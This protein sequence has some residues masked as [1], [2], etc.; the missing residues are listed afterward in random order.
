MDWRKTGPFAL[1]LVAPFIAWLLADLLIRYHFSE[2]SFRG[3][4]FSEARWDRF[5]RTTSSGL[6]TVTLGGVLLAATAAAGCIGKWRG[7]SWLDAFARAAAANASAFLLVPHWALCFL[8]APG[9]D[10]A[11]SE[12]FGWLVAQ[13]PLVVS[14]ALG[15]WLAGLWHAAWPPREPDSERASIAKVLLT[16]SL[17]AAA[18]ATL[19]IM[20]AAALHVP[21]GDTAMYEEHLWNALHGKGFRSQLDDGRLFLGEHFQMLHLFLTPIYLFYPSLAT[22]NA[23]QAIALASGALAVYLIARTLGLL[24]TTGW[25]LAL[26]YLAYFPLQ[27]LCLEASWKTFRPTSLAVPLVLYGLLALERHRL[28]AAAA[29]LAMTLLAEEEYAILVAAVG[30]YLAIRRGRGPFGRREIG[31]GLG[32]T[33]G[34]CLFLVLALGVLIPSFRHGQV[35]HYTPYFG[36]LGSS[37]SE[38][39]ATLLEHPEEIPKRLATIADGQF[40]LLMLLPLG[41]LPLASPARMLVTLPIFGYL[42]L[43]DRPALVQPWFHFHGPLVP[44]L[45]W[46]MVGGVANVGRWLDRWT[47]GL[48]LARLVA[49]LCL[50][51]GVWY[52]RSPLSWRFHDPTDAVPWQ[53]TPAGPRF[54]PRGTYW[55][56][57]YLPRERARAFPSVMPLIAPT[58]RVAATDYLRPR[59]THHRAAHDYP[60]LR[61][62][63]TIDDIDVILIDKTE[64]WWGRGDTNPDKELLAC[65]ADPACGP[66]KRL[67]IRERPFVVQYHDPYFL[68][69][70]RVDRAAAPI[71]K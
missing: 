33:V 8:A 59:F 47:S 7:R 58:D 22:L 60:T 64:G 37:P 55:R 13:T 11:P 36:S 27:Y 42:M 48:F 41:L 53:T 31:V 19:A 15:G 18:F 70:R 2:S 66:G 12:Q 30:L 56:S 14:L 35:P 17:F 49:S 6:W 54:E 32:L 40:L 20:Q 52:G 61:G 63:V 71:T 51:T 26:A 23:C 67:R 39:G 1:A 3:V 44:L 65:L 29:L 38:I 50:A 9:A 62:H 4:L 43:A 45:F 28:A 5:A 10:Q 57:V 68:L 21:H 25:A 34:A 46:A 16:A 24:P 69:V